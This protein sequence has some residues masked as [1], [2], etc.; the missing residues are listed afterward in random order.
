MNSFRFCF[1]A[2]LLLLSL[3]EAYYLYSCQARWQECL[4]KLGLPLFV[5]VINNIYSILKRA[6]QT[7]VGAM[8]CKLFQ[9]LESNRSNSAAFARLRLS[10][11]IY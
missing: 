6:E 3:Q 1:P 9:H 7:V 4:K 5:L 10:C 2:F 8:Y 11:F